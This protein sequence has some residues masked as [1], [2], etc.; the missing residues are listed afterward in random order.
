H[1]GPRM[2]F[3]R[4]EFLAALRIL[5]EQGY[6]V[7]QM[8]SSWAGAFGQTQFTPTTF[9][10]F[11]ADGDGDRRIDLWD[12]RADA[13]ASAAALLSGQ[14]WQRNESWGAEITL[15]KGFAYDQADVEIVKPVR[16]WRR[17]GVRTLSGAALPPDDT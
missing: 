12:S 8:R 3:G 11:A 5:Q 17:L 16:E 9:L 1:D 2:A 15:P 10:R 7:S 13:L 6:V 14:G 4:A